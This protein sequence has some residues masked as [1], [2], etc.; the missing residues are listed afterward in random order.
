MVDTDLRNEQD[1]TC[2]A[3][4]VTVRLSEFNL[5]I[6]QQIHFDSSSG[7]YEYFYKMLWQSILGILLSWPKWWLNNQQFT[8]QRNLG[9][10]VSENKEL[11][12][13]NATC[14]HR[15]VFP[16]V[17]VCEL[18]FQ[19]GS[20]LIL[21]DIAHLGRS[22]INKCAFFTFNMFPK[23][24]WTILLEQHFAFLGDR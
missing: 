3:T 21:A 20:L 18:S 13:I 12:K 11:R 7:N 6:I 4:L 23:S 9:M 19:G 8:S 14:Q 22:C 10:R 16:E 2:T 1:Y 15:R 17:N 5:I 24:S